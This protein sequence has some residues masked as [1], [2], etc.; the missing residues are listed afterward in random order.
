MAD[1]SDRFAEGAKKSPIADP[2][3]EPPVELLDA[4][5]TDPMVI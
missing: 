4:S 2:V 5:P 3:L 1:A